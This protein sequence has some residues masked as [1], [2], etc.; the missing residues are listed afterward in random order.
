MKFKKTFRRRRRVA[1]LH[2]QGFQKSLA[3]PGASRLRLHIPA[4]QLVNTDKI[5]ILR[6]ASLMKYIIKKIFIKLVNFAK[7]LALAANEIAIL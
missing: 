3:S 4:F 7:V 5:A 1:R 6:H 2:L